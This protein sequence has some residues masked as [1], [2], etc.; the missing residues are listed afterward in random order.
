MESVGLNINRK[1]TAT[2]KLENIW[3]KKLY[4]QEKEKLPK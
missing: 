3:M 1:K 2:G 4:S